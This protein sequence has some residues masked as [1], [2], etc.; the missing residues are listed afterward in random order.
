MP[1]QLFLRTCFLLIVTLWLTACSQPTSLATTPAASPSEIPEL[2]AKAILLPAITAPDDSS[3]TLGITSA[4][5]VSPSII[6]STTALI[7]TPVAPSGATVSGQVITGFGD[8]NPVAGLL[9]RIRQ[10]NDEVWDTYT[11]GNGY[12][13][14]KNLPLGLVNID[15]D[16]LSFQVTITST[17]QVIDLGKL[18]YP[19][20]HPPLYDWWRAAPLANLSD[21]F[22]KG[23]Q[24]PFEICITRPDW[25][26]PHAEVERE[27]V[28]SKPPFI[29]LGIQRYE[30][31]AILYDTIDLTQQSFPD[32]PD[33]D[34]LGSEW[35]YRTGLWT[36]PNPITGSDC[37][38]DPQT[39]DQ[40]L[41][42]DRLEVWLFGYNAIQVQR[43]SKDSATFDQ[44]SLCNTEL[45][46]CTVRPGS[47]YAVYVIPARGFQIIRFQ[48]EEDVLSVHIIQGKLDIL[49]LP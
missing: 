28:L 47:H 19:L 43:L 17:S 15:D 9:L 27:Q 35:L 25:V 40:L 48:G 31:P 2:T 22:T 44:T 11:D 5:P 16:H 32:G 10:K 20:I 42:R 6:P 12:F 21:L 23:E 36:A 13:T 49:T 46:D 24:I 8:H 7:G 26:K 39:L 38:Y 29:N 1:T 33:L 41:Y 14:L 18:R 34:E 30:K 3:A 45:R 4:F 37:S